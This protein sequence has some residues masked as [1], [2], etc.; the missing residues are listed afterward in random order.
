MHPA[1]ER[2]IVSDE[3]GAAMFD[4]ALNAEKAF[5]PSQPRDESGKWTDAGGGDGGSGSGDKP[6]V[7]T[8]E[9]AKLDPT[10]VEVGGDEW[11]RATARRLEIQYQEAKPK[12]EE[13]VKE[14]LGKEVAVPDL[15]DEDEDEGEPGFEPE[16]W[17]ML[18]KSGQEQVKDHYLENNIDDYIQ[19]EVDNWYESGQALDQAKQQ[20]TEEF[21]DTAPGSRASQ[22]WINDAIEEYRSDQRIPYTTEQL[23]AA[24]SLEYQDGY[25]GGGKFTVEFDDSELQQPSKLP[26]PGQ[27]TLPGIE[28][29]KPEEQL[30]EKMRDD[31]T[32]LIEKAFDKKSQDLSGDLQAPE[33]LKE[34]AQ[35]FAAENWDSNM[36]DKDKFEYAK[37]NTSVVEDETTE[38][39]GSYAGEKTTTAS[40]YFSIDALPKEYDPLNKTS[41]E[42]YKRTQALA[43]YLSVERSI[44]VMKA[45]NIE[46][47]KT[48]IAT[49]DK[50]LWS[51]WKESSTSTSGQLLQMATADE[52]GGRLRDAQLENGREQLLKF[53]DH[54]YANIGGYAGVKAYVRAKWEV[55]QYLL[56]RAGVKELEVYRGIALPKDILEKSLLLRQLVTQVGAA[57]LLPNMHVERNGAASTTT[58]PNV[59]NRWKRDTDRVVLRAVVP[60]T[61]AVSLPVYGINIHSEH[62]V[63]V[64]G[65]AW[66]G[67]DAWRGQAPSLVAVP[68]QQHAA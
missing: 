9:S 53:A 14:A 25:D 46:A 55:S 63:V 21:N 59:A 37:H 39:T 15:S 42:D 66:K 23:M 44:Q 12:I 62:E 30:T 29:I 28:P 8:A 40:D 49:V 10:V 35:E 34:S 27:G 1:V 17:D 56:D 36:E 48:E 13:T 11:N 38:G 57:K 5:D 32:K 7:A 64:A 26:P 54:N 33:Y 24:I 18:S 22:E 45:R 50:R 47:S 2:I 31:L 68:L 3:E 67:W 43:L 51:S 41:G 4:A 6:Q 65:T 20:V 58:D 60:R 16:E 61:A 52:L 19:S